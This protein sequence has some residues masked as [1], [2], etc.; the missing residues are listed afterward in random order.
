[1]ED[2]LLE[3]QHHED[4]LVVALGGI[5]DILEVYFVVDR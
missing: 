2:T 4:S 5:E 1:V 3:E